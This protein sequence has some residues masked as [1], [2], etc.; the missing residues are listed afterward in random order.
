M[1]SVT[2]VMTSEPMAYREK[3][4]WLSL[5]AMAVTFGPY[6]TWMA[7]W[8]PTEPL[9]DLV[10]M[11][12]FA[13]T[14]LGQALILGIGRCYLRRRSPADARAP[15]DERDRAITLRSLGA[16][17]YVLIVGTILVGCVM[18]FHSGGWQ[19]INAAVAMLVLAEVVHYGVAA[20][21]YRRGFHDR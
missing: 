18:P 11:G 21:G 17:Y 13:A 16:A 3:I 19:L 4:A 1:E 9:P 6:F 2:L 12:R 14:V 5:L 8:P 15:A 20:H 7:I 10:T